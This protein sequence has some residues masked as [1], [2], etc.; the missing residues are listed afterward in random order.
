MVSHLYEV[1]GLFQEHAYKVQ[2]GSLH[3]VLAW[4]VQV[5]GEIEFPP[6]LVEREAREANTRQYSCGREVDLTSLLGHSLMIQSSYSTKAPK[7]NKVIESVQHKGHW[8]LFC[9]GNHLSF[10]NVT[11]P[12]TKHPVSSVPIHRMSESTLND[13]ISLQLAVH[14]KNQHVS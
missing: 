3:G 7:P 5:Y 6:V 2:E 11:L 12:E 1:I 14:R 9:L 8:H 4:V 10:S 13:S